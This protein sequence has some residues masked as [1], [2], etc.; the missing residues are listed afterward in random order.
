MA[1]PPL[2]KNGG[3]YIREGCTMR[4][5][6]KRI[7]LMVV[8]A[9]MLLAALGAFHLATA[10]QRGAAATVANTP[11][12]G[13]MPLPIDLWNTKNFYLDR[14]LWTDK[15]YARCNTPH[16]LTDMWPDGTVGKW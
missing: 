15:R 3:E 5:V 6:L 16:Q 4:T 8:L 9:A 11:P 12:A 2:L 10:Q 13:I 14:K 1:R 7:S